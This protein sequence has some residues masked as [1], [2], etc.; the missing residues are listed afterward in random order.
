MPGW[1]WLFVGEGVPSV[2]LG[3]L[4]FFVLTD[5]PEQAAWLPEDERQWLIETLEIE[6]AEISVVESVDLST[7]WRNTLMWRL[8]A[9]YFLLSVGLYSLS[10]WLPVVLK[11]ISGAS[12]ASVIL[13]TAV[14]W[15]VATL[16]MLADRAFL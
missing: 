1:K 13:L 3:L 8:S 15:L 4:V 16:A 10:L 6:R 9:I 14:P 2:L 7:L 12:E 5:T 11:Q